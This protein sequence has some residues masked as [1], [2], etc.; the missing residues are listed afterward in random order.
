MTIQKMPECG[1][2]GALGA[3][4][5]TWPDS[6]LGVAQQGG[7]S[8]LRV[9]AVNSGPP[10]L[11]CSAPSVE[12]DQLTR[13]DPQQ[14]KGPPAKPATTLDNYCSPLPGGRNLCARSSDQV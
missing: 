9:G 4:L 7:V 12:T 1:L 2:G 10:S 11:P 3:P 8:A 6:G 13:K 5:W 14:E